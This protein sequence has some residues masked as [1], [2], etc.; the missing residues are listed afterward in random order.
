MIYMAESQAGRSP[1]EWREAVLSLPR[2]TQTKGLLFSCVAEAF[3]RAGRRDAARSFNDEALRLAP[4]R[5]EPHLQRALWAL[6]AGG[7][8][9]AA[10]WLR[11]AAQRQESGGEA[12]YFLERTGMAIMDRLP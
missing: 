6:G 10:P 1:E 9:E 7:A 8:K 12:Q 3:W 2:E 5:A 4:G 11:Q